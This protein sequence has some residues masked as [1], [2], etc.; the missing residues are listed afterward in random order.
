MKTCE[1]E[2]RGKVLFYNKEINIRE[3]DLNIWH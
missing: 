1:K 2:K 3:N